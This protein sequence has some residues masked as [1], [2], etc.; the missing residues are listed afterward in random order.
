MAIIRNLKRFFYKPFTNTIPINNTLLFADIQITNRKVLET[1]PNWVDDEAMKKSCFAYGMPKHIQQFINLPLSISPTYSD[2]ICYFSHLLDG[3]VNYLEIGVSVGKNFFQV[4]NY[5]ENAR[6][7]GF[8]IEEINPPLCN[9]LSKGESQKWGNRP[10]SVKK[11]P[12]SLTN[13]HFERTNNEIVYLSADVFDEVS[14]QKLQGQKFNLIFSDAF[15][16]AKALRL[17]YEMMKKYDLLADKFLFFWDDLH[18][19]MED[20]F[21]EISQDLGKKYGFGKSNIFLFKTSGWIGDNES[22]H[23]IGLTSSINII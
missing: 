13:Y 1:I 19:D 22:K 4:M 3:N 12:P 6:M 23:P 14:W 20:T 11:T 8:E 18:F 5:L 17:E 15:H 21:V 10:E 9:I 16:D 7:T 2:F